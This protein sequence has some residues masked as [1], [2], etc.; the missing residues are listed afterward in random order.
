MKY[1]CRDCTLYMCRLYGDKKMKQS[2]LEDIFYSYFNNFFAILSMLR[3][4]EM[5]QDILLYTHV[6]LQL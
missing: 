4:A 1:L 3:P 2:D 6:I 5:V